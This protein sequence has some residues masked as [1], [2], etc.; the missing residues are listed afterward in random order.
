VE[1]R[2]PRTRFANTIDQHAGRLQFAEAPGVFC[3]L[4]AHEDVDERAG[5]HADDRAESRH[6]FPMRVEFLHDAGKNCRDA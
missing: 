1:D 5:Q 2:E 6:F 3:A 4:A